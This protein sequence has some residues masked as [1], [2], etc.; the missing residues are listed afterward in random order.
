MQAR[1]ILR[2][3]PPCPVV[4]PAARRVAIAQAAWRPGTRAAVGTL[5]VSPA[6]VGELDGLGRA[7]AGDDTGGWSLP[8]RR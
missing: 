2:R 3:R 7:G 5:R 4:G 1:G 8:T 6:A